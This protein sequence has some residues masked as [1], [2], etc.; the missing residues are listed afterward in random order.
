MP[1]RFLTTALAVLVSFNL[2]ACAGAEPAEAG[3]DSAITASAE[4][5]RFLETRQPA[6]YADAF[7]A[8]PAEMKAR[9]AVAPGLDVAPVAPAQKAGVANDPPIA[10]DDR[11]LAAKIVEECRAQYLCTNGGELVLHREGT[12]CL[13]GDVVLSSDWTA[14]YRETGIFP[15]P[16]SWRAG[17]EYIDVSFHD[18][19]THCD[20]KE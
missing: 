12:S 9:A 6:R 15:G 16:G 4:D 18:A 2:I 17:A 7:P 13:L 10:G 8:S 14:H 3:T 5:E 20:R 1:E 11:A 19:L